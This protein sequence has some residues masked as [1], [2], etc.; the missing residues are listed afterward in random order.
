[1]TNDP[2]E[3]ADFG[4]VF[5]PYTTE[6]TR[7][8]KEHGGRFVYYTTADVATHI[9]TSR[10]MWMRN[11]L[12]MNDFAEVSYGFNCV[13]FA[14]DGRCGEILGEALNKCFPGLFDEVKIML[15]DHSFIIGAE[16]YMT[17]LSEHLG[18]ED[19]RGRLSMWR[20]YGGTTGV[21]IVMNGG[22]MFSASDALKAYSSPVFYG[23]PDAFA[24][25][26]M[27]VVRSI[28]SNGQLLAKLGRETVKNTVFE[29]LRF[30]VLCTKHPGFREEREWRVI[31]A[32]RLNP[33]SRLISGVELVRGV[34][35]IVLK[36]ELKNVPEEGL[37]GLAPAEL[38]NR[39]IIG[40]CEFP[41]PTYQAFYELLTRLGIPDPQSR[42]VISDIPLRHTK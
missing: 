39:I 8:A 26:F 21:A 24:D 42:I 4:G 12:V 31:A 34:P 6:R 25:E 22:V 36:I 33:S 11:A 15:R 5:F 1:M 35:Q 32:P 7:Q 17:C 18:D 20:A 2:L 38:I 23:D 19:E 37:E 27:K 41:I 10:Q 9:L 30:A 29:I 40:P 13:N 28:Q 3:L 16:T 14:L